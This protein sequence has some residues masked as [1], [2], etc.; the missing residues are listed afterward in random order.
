MSSRPDLRLDWCSYSAA[1]YAVE[2]WHYSERMPVGKLVKIGV[3]EDGRFIGAIVFGQGNNQYQGHALGLRLQ[4]VCELVRVALRHHRTPVSRI[5][6][7]ACR[8]LRKVN[9]GLRAVVSYAD[10][11]KG[12]H[13]GIYQAGGW[14]YVGTGGSHEAFYSPSGQ[15]L[16]SRVVS[17]SGMKNHFGRMTRSMRTSDVTRVP[18]PPKYKYLLGLDDEIKSRLVSLAQPYPSA[19]RLESEAPSVQLGDEGAAMRP[20]RSTLPVAAVS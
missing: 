9:P 2:H 20:T 3:W 8:M 7:V 17:A 18:L 19:S 5:V 11:A 13:G 6:A 1:K 15:R 14:V 10:P 16:H 4:E 12:H